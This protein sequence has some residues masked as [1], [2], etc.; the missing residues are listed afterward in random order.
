MKTILIR[1]ALLFLIVI[2]VTFV[3]WKEFD[4]PVI[5]ID[6]ANIFLVYAKH[7]IHG[8]GL[9]YN[10]GGERVEGFSSPLWMLIAAVAFGISDQPEFGLLL[11]NVLLVAGTLTMTTLFLDS[12][13]FGRQP[14][15]RGWQFSTCSLLYLCMV[16]VSPAYFVWGILTLMENGLWGCV[17]T[18]TAITALARFQQRAGFLSVL[19]VLLL[20]TRPEAMLWSVVLIGILFFREAH[21]SN[22]R[23]G[24][25]AIR[26]PL[27]TCVATLLALTGF[28]LLYF[29]YPLPNTYYA[30]ISPSFL[31]NV[32]EGWRY[33]TG[34]FYSAP[35]V[36]LSILV[37][38][39]S[40][41]LNGQ[42]IVRA[43]VSKRPTSRTEQIDLLPVVICVGLM[44]PILTGGDHFSLWRFYQPLYPL[45]LLNMFLFGVNI[46]ETVLAVQ[47]REPFSGTRRWLSVVMLCL[48]LYLTQPLR[49]E[50]IK[51][52]GNIDYEFALAED[53]RY[54][55][56]FFSNFF[57]DAA[58]YPSIGVIVAG[59]VKMT[60]QGDI[61]DL[62]GL[63][64]IKMGHGEGKR[65]GVKNHAAFEKAIFYELQPDAFNPFFSFAPITECQTEQN[66]RNLYS[67]LLKHPGLKNWLKG[68]LSEVEFVNS[69]Q[70]VQIT[71]KKFTSNHCFI[72]FVSH[73]FLLKMNADENYRIQDAAAPIQ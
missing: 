36:Q 59:G 11:I 40:F 33:V 72:G 38:I 65:L 22:L 45:L 35:L 8:H 31:Y 7:L 61:I 32:S 30:K 62:M 34:F 27:A 15:Q 55:G 24:I 73:P 50:N 13:I 2:T 37:L 69:Y 56:R 53:A 14:I 20:L 29:G 39:F 16:C 54:M 18:A 71:N 25:A 26:L 60:Y 47:W 41:A 5:G 21:A 42:R 58:S 48:F 4:Y 49:W 67:T 12:Q 43:L 6:D 23:E 28:R 44:I 57:A 10:I 66:L 70:F 9:V 3:I 46:T 68:L 63:N 19:I 1:F 17:F 52:N 51:E 64:N